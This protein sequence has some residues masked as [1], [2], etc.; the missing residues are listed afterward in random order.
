M[1]NKKWTPSQEE[2][3]GVITNVYKSIK[4]DLSELQKETGC[5]DSF[6]YDFIG[7]I[8]YEWH[9]E[10]CHSI[11]RNKKKKNQKILKLQQKIY[12]NLKN[13]F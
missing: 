12:K 9:P 2:N 11:V 7:K 5:P 13:I 8:Q 1:E 4:E 6:I 3:I 10:S